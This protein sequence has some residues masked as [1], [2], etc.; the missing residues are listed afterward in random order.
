M[1]IN[2]GVNI[3]KLI[4][5][6]VLAPEPGINI[7]KMLGYGVLGVNPGVSIEKFLAYGVLGDPNVAP[8][9]WGDWTFGDGTQYVPY[10]QTWDMPTAAPG[11]AYS[12][13]AGALPD[14]LSLTALTGNQAKISG[15]PLVVNTFN[16]TLRATNT[17]GTVDKAFSITINLPVAGTGGS[18]GCI[19]A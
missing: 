7:T 10:S 3:S 14:G 8:P 16:F 9:I 19:F 2:A 1:A 11:V 15:T 4:G 6:G 13:V 18:G 5:Y 12:V 17:Y